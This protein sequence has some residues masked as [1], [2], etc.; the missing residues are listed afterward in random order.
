MRLRHSGR[1]D[2]A[3]RE[4]AHPHTPCLPC[5][6][7]QEVDSTIS[8]RRPAYRGRARF[9]GHSLQYA[10]MNT[11]NPPD[12]ALAAGS[13]ERLVGRPDAPLAPDAG[14]HVVIERARLASLLVDSARDWSIEI[15]EQTGSTNADLMHRLRES[16]TLPAPLAR[17]AYQQDAGRGR[18]GRAWLAAPGHALLFSLAYPLQRPL[19]GLAGLSL[20]VGTAITAGLR[21]LPLRQPDRLAL[22]WPNDILLDEAKLGGVLIETAW[23]TPEMSAV[24]IGIGLN[25]RGAAPLAAQ[26]AALAAA[27]G[28]ANGPATTV[29]ALEQLWPQPDITETLAQLLNALAH[30]LARFSQAGFAPF[31]Q[32]WLADHAYAGR[33]VALLENGVTIA[34]GTAESVDALGQLL[35]GTPDGTRSCAAGDV[36]LRL[37]HGAVGTAPDGL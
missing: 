17:V 20:A 28:E 5:A 19:D 26:L 30:T 24:I 7:D 21:A 14:C 35:I 34:S 37:R 27:A 25:L 23:S 15:V 36:S 22:K 9:A 4:F 12:A 3:L 16:R 31:R 8:I 11:S 1:L 13:T 18:R 33:P 2:T 29:A 10:Y 32:L 6:A